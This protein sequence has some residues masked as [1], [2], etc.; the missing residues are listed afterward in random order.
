MLAGIDLVIGAVHAS[1]EEGHRSREFIGFL[2]K[3][4]ATHPSSAAIKLI[5]DNYSAH[6]SK[7]TKAWLATQP[8]GRFLLRVLE[9][10]LI[11]QPRRGLFL[12]AR[13]IGTSIYPRLVHLGDG[14]VAFALAFATAAA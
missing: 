9:A 13:T 2:Q 11:D 3:L 12:Q 6:I 10:L 1:V 14:H 5:L 7:E 8:E 4:D